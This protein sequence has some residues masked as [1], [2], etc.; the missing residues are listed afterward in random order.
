MQNGTYYLNNRGSKWITFRNGKKVKIKFLT[1]SG[2]EIY[3]TAIYFELFGN[4][5]S[6]L[7]SYKGKKINVLTDTIL[8]D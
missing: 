8:K 1:E 6:V 3:R 4:F 2:K 5:S 7:I